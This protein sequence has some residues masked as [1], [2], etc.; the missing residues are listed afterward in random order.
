[1]FLD[2]SDYS[3]IWLDV[4]QIASGPFLSTLCDM[5]RQRSTGPED[6]F[7]QDISKFETRVCRARLM[8][9]SNIDST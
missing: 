2:R 7:A 3:D 9:P 8:M 6:G 5:H 1:M 4:F